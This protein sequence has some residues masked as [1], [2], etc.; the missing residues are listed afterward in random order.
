METTRSDFNCKVLETENLGTFLQPGT[1][2][3]PRHKL[4]HCHEQSPRLLSQ[5]RFQRI[6]DWPCSVNEKKQGPVD[7]QD[8]PPTRCEVPALAEVGVVLIGRSFYCFIAS[9]GDVIE[10]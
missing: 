4:S 3:L 6:P 7:D 5:R 1:P 10:G 2:R 9:M 8:R